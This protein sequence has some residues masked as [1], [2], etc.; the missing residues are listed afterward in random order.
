MRRSIRGKVAVVTGAGGGLGRALCLELA[1]RGACIAALERNRAALD[2]VAA[3]ISAA[4]AAVLPGLCDVTD[5][6]SC[7]AAMAD[8]ERV[9]GGVDILINNAGITH[10]SAFRAT[11][12]A[13]LGRV[14]AVNVMGAVHATRA[15][16]D[17]LIARQGAIVAISSV[18]GFA[19]LIART[20]YAASKH[21]LHGFFGSLRTELADSG[22]DIT[23]VCPSFIATGIERAAL[24]PDGRS[25]RQPQQIIGARATPDTIAA[26]VCDA[27]ERR[28]R[29]VIPGR[30]A[31]LAWFTSRF[32]PRFYER[33]MRRRLAGE[34][35]DG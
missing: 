31:K 8:V 10:R 30:V 28:R 19:P 33:G 13:V 7:R 5:F 17:S 9:L 16:L 32:L 3:D 34:M 23:L 25:A 24:G 4:G 2:A 14:M 29:L 35:V 6:D 11:D 20:G 1:A 26:I 15:A 21:A 12:P 27:I 18:A 22:V